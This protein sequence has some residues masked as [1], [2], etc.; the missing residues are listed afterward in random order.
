VPE[1]QR[2]SAAPLEPEP[3]GDGDDAPADRAAELTPEPA[4]HSRLPET[5]APCSR[6]SGSWRAPSPVAPE[7]AAT[8]PAGAEAAAGKAAVDQAA[9]EALAQVPRHGQVV[10][11]DEALLGVGLCH[12]VDE[13]TLGGLAQ[14]GQLQG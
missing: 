11:E 8:L 3:D 7:L 1:K 13:P 4:E 14:Q 10:A 2:Q 6:G 9:L 12:R 5:S